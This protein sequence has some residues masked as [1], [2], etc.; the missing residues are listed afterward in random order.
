MLRVHGAI[1]KQS[2]KERYQL[3]V[4]PYLRSIVFYTSAC[5]E[6][7]RIGSTLS[8]TDSKYG[9]HSHYWNDED[10]T[11]DCQL[12]QWGVE[13]LFQ[14]S[15]EAITR[16]LKLYIKDR[17]KMNIKNKSQLSCTMFLT[18]Y[19]SLVLYDEYLEKIFIIDHEQLEF[20]K[21]SG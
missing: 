1:L 8:H 12:Y 18:K 5:I 17:E 6:E 14:N 11:F 15:D 19:D 2:S 13:K 3:L 21:N 20:N 16:Y 10:H 7:A 9:P 4:V